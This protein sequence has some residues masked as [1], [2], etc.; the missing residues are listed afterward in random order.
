MIEHTQVF[1]HVGLLRNEPP[2][3]A[4]LPFIKS[5]DELQGSFYHVEFGKTTA[6]LKSKSV[7]GIRPELNHP[8]FISCSQNKCRDPIAIPHES[9]NIQFVVRA[10]V[11]P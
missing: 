5:S 3:T 9:R 11:K 8:L 6:F 4:G 1:I 2:D 10:E 7:T